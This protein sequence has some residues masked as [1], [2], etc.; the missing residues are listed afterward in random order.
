MCGL[1]L[2]LIAGGLQVVSGA[3]GIGG[4]QAS[5]SY[6]QKLAKRNQMIAGKAAV[7]QYGAIQQSIYEAEIQAAQAIRNTKSEALRAT[8]RVQA[9]AGEANIKG[10]AIEA[11]MND[12]ARQ[13]GQ[14]IVASKLNRDFSR[15]QGAHELEAAQLGA[16][17]QFLAATPPPSPDIFSQSL[18]VLGSA[19]G[20][21]MQADSLV[22][23][24]GGTP[25][26]LPE[27]S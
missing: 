27:V 13:E 9:A 23:E 4:D 26:L 24:A 17:S 22:R 3:M 8:G 18:G 10:A 16:E 2:P 12:F 25:F 14:A 19:F 15:T 7:N 21:T 1:P 11:L 20:A 5:A 6:Q